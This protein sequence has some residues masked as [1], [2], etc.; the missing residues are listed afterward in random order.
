MNEETKHSRQKP[1]IDTINKIEGMIF[2]LAF[3]CTK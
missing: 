1:Y 2:I 3:E